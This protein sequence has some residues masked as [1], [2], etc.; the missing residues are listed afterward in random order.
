LENKLDYIQG[1]GSRAIWISP[2]VLNVDGAYHGYYPKDFARLDPHWGSMEDLRSLVDAAHERGIYVIIDVVFN[3]T[4]RLLTSDAP[5]YARFNPEGY[6]LQ[7]K[8]D[9]RYAPPFDDPA[10]FHGMGH[11]GNF[12]DRQQYVMGSLQGLNDIRT[13]SPLV[14]DALVEAYS[15]WVTDTDC[16]GFRFDTAAHVALEDWQAMLPRLREHVASLGK[17][18]FLFL[19]ECLRYADSDVG[20]FTRTGLFNSALYYPL[21]STLQDVL[22]GKQPT[23]ALA[24]RLGHRQAYGEFSNQL[25][26][27][28]DNHD[29]PRMMSPEQLAGDTGQLKAALAFLMTGPFVPC[30]YYGTEQ[31]FDGKSDHSGREDMFDGQ[32]EQ[33]TSL[34]DNFDMLSPLYR[35]ASKLHRLREKFP[36]LR[37]GAFK[38]R[39]HEPRG[40]GL[41]VFSRLLGEQEIIVA[42]NT[43]REERAAVFQGSGP[44]TDLPAGTRLIDALDPET[45]CIVEKVGP[46]NRVRFSVPP[47]YARIFVAASVNIDDPLLVTACSPQH[48]RFH[49]PRRQ[50]ISLEFNRPMDPLSV[51]Q[52]LTTSPSTAGKLEWSENHRL[53]I[54]SPQTRFAEAETI[55]VRLSTGARAKDGTSLHHPFEFQFHTGA[56]PNLAKPLGTFVLDGQLDAEIPQVD[57]GQGFTLYVRYD[58]D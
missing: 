6:P 48:D 34:G 38:S 23:R 10:N 5:G 37:R 55:T 35:F 52:A 20:P 29:K 4:A 19:A 30:L 49:V 47:N 22:V 15:Q 51:E 2:V 33:N 43:S 42:I 40:P 50:P 21:Y 56:R 25:V 17:T 18:N 54:Y 53:V 44:I 11:I 41:F 14:R 39:W 13:E 12:N 27:F 1:L 46:N 26:A 28:L 16:D 36:P 57:S 58:R 7:W 45:G 31:A 32:F 8:D 24:D 3:H 9:R